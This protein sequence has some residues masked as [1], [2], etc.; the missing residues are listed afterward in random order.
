MPRVE[1]SDDQDRFVVVTGGAMGIGAAI[2]E[3]FARSGA[4]VSILDI[5]GDA[6]SSLAERLVADGHRVVS[7]TGDVSSASEAERMILDS[8]SALGGLNVLVNNAGIQPKSSNVRVEDLDE[9]T[10]D[11]VIDVNLKGQFLMSKF[12]IPYIRQ[13]GGGTIINIASVQGLQSRTKV[14]VYAASKGGI[15][16]LTRNMALDYVKDNIRVVAINPGAI[17]DTSL[18]LSA[19]EIQ[20]RTGDGLK[21]QSDTNHNLDWVNT[22]GGRPTGNPYD[23][24]TVAVFLASNAAS[25][26]TGESINVDGGAMAIGAWALESRSV[27]GPPESDG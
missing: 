19:A 15:L 22:V 11:R 17:P 2:A 6:A 16:S 20:G 25:F 5:D 7:F 27:L 10:W 23:I 12:S 13:Q 26:I 3:C 1:I 9:T 8:V 24:G 4:A 21:V 14:P 18:G